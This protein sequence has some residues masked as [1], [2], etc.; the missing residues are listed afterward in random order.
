MSWS[1]RQPADVT[2]KSET[3]K[4]AIEAE[5]TPI[6]NW[7]EE[8]VPPKRPS[9]AFPGPNTPKRSKS[10]RT[11]TKTPAQS[12]TPAQRVTSLPETPV[13]KPHYEVDLRAPLPQAAV[14]K[15]TYCQCAG[16]GSFP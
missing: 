13:S 4:K 1:Y 2:G 8:G 16:V 5:R 10:T 14:C 11:E 9:E 7:R 6:K 15:H 12:K 3:P